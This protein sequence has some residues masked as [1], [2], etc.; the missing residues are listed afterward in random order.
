[1]LIFDYTKQYV[2]NSDLKFINYTN[3][4]NK[5]LDIHIESFP[6]VTRYI[7]Y[8]MSWKLST[9]IERYSLWERY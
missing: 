6:I 1:M 7:Q 4:L 8:K 2:L 5:F 3:Y 9:Y